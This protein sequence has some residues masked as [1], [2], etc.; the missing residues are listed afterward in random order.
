[1]PCV[2]DSGAPTGVMPSHSARPTGSHTGTVE[3]GWRARLRAAALATPPRA[4]RA[5]APALPAA[6]AYS[7]GD[8]AIDQTWLPKR[9]TNRRM[10]FRV[11]GVLAM[12]DGAGP[13]PVIFVLHDAHGGC[14]PDR[15]QQDLVTDT[16][17]CLPAEE[18][19]NDIGLSYLLSNLAARGY[20]AVGQ[21]HQAI[22]IIIHTG[23][24]RGPGCAIPPRDSIG[25]CPARCRCKIASRHQVA[26]WKNHQAVLKTLT[27]SKV[28]VKISTN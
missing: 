12:P 11:E 19:R 2:A 3:T 20:I 14:F 27:N 23:S 4:L 7:L 10:P 26:A 13:F 21:H 6:R 24:E 9:D 17:P 28:T 5:N 1:M 8:S 18:R 16:W 22:H 15:S 25:G